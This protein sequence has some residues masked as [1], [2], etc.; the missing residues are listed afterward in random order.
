M[1]S[2]EGDGVGIGPVRRPT[3]GGA[4]G[5]PSPGWGEGRPFLRLPKSA[6]QMWGLLGGL[7]DR[8]LILL[9]L[10]EWQIIFFITKEMK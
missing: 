5:S 4:P 6:T 2:E 1:I 10:E 9:L 8:L 3:I 7:F